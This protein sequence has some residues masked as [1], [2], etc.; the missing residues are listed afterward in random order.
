[1]NDIIAIR[2][3]FLVE[4]F[5]SFLRISKTSQIGGNFWKHFI[6]FASLCFAKTS[7]TKQLAKWSYRKNSKPFCETMNH[8]TPCMLHDLMKFPLQ[9]SLLST[10]LCPFSAP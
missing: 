8:F 9:P 3:G 10:A 2:Q 5:I 4:R 7:K 1:V 6:C